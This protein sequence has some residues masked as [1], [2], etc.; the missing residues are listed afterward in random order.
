MYNQEAEAMDRERLV[1]LQCE[2]LAATLARTRK[3]EFYRRRLKEAGLDSE[4]V[5]SLTV[6]EHLPFTTKQDL[7]EQSPFGLL[8][9][10]RV[11]I[12]RFHATSGTKGRPILVACTAGDLEA[13]AELC[14]R[15]LA[16]A[17]LRAGEAMHNALNYGLFTGGLGVHGGAERL[18]CAVIP[19]SGGISRRQIQLIQDL[20]PKAIKSTPSCLLHLADVAEQMA[21]DTA[22]L[23]VRSAILGGGA[24]VG[25]V[26]PVD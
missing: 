22:A 2:R 21:V 6:L 5:T 23:G 12:A 9:V 3:V 4:A 18:G 26:P 20:E 17:G 16:A 14:A 7:R 8:A 10:T 24:L 15:F 1:G 19:A 11:R 25:S 13:W